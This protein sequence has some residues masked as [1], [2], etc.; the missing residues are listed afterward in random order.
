MPLALPLNFKESSM[1][2][3]GSI[4]HEILIEIAKVSLE[5]LRV[6][7]TTIPGCWKSGSIVWM[8]ANSFPTLNGFVLRGCSQKTGDSLTRFC[9][10]RHLSELLVRVEKPFERWI[11]RRAGYTIPTSKAQTLLADLTSEGFVTIFLEPASP[12]ADLFSLTTVCDVRSEKAD[13]EVVGPGFD[14][15]DILRSDIKPH[16][17][18]EITLENRAERSQDREFQLRRTYLINSEGYRAS[19]RRRLIKIGARLRNPSFPDDLMQP[20]A[21]A[22]T[23]DALLQNATRYL[24]ES[25]Q[26]VLL[27]HAEEYKPI[28][29]GLLDEF[30][31]QILRLSRAVSKSDVPWRTFSL[32]GSFL[33]GERLVLWDFFPPGE[34]DTQTLANLTVPS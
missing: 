34:Y 29:R 24:R 33:P 1:A 20:N 12:C 2:P 8:L 31:L 27:D 26:T 4:E 14:A 22:A 19:V 17:R 30:L 9:Q 3:L 16:E 7:L 5:N 6:T 32:A 13:I 18:F 15:S 28:P 11:R 10:D 23:L 21:T 25:G